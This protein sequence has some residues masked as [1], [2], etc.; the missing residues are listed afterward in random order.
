[1]STVIIVAVSIATGMSTELRAA[2]CAFRVSGS[3]AAGGSDGP[4]SLPSP[5]SGRVPS[6][7]ALPPKLQSSHPAGGAAD[8]VKAVRSLPG[9]PAA[10]Q[11]ADIQVDRQRFRPH[12]RRLRPADTGPH[13]RQAEFVDAERLAGVD[14]LA[15]VTGA[16]DDRQVVIALRRPF[17]HG[18]TAFADA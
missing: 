6:R 11:I 17:R 16:G 3:V 1:I 10:R 13:R 15:L 18:P 8:S 12:R 14:H 5:S 7:T 2:P 9:S 4:V